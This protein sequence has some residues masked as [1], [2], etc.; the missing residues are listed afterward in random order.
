[1]RILH[2]GMNFSENTFKLLTEDGYQCD[3]SHSVEG[4]SNKL[5]PNAEDIDK[6]GLTEYDGVFVA[7]LYISN[8]VKKYITKSLDNGLAVI[9][10]AKEKG[11]P[12][13]VLADGD[14]YARASEAGATAI[15]GTDANSNVFLKRAQDTFIGLKKSEFKVTDAD[16]EP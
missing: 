9:R 13:V 7:N 12:C 1:M 14:D 8:K 15:A 11:I 6:Y 10:L 16:D 5:N 2:V 4:V 3:Q